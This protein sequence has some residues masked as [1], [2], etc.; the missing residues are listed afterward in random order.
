MPRRLSP[1][2]LDSSD[3]IETERSQ[4]SHHQIRISGARHRLPNLVPIVV[5]IINENELLLS[6][7]HGR[8]Q[9]FTARHDER[10]RGQSVGIMVTTNGSITA[11]IRRGARWGNKVGGYTRFVKSGR[12]RHAAQGLSVNHKTS[13]GE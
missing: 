6:F 13:Q 9:T 11:N 1:S 8:R 3:A 12:V 10:H 2:T 5:D 7:G 4:G